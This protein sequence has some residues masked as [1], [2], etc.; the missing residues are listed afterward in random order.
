M[1]GG[2]QNSWGFGRA[3]YPVV[4]LSVRHHRI[5]SPIIKK[6]KYTQQQQQY[7]SRTCDDR[8]RTRC[9]HTEKADQFPSF[10]FDMDVYSIPTSFD[11]FRH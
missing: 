11:R 5:I 1:E 3:A 10:L 2:E 4:V 6:S 9:A 7:Q 8:Q